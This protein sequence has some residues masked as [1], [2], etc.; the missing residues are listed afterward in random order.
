VLPA[1]LLTISKGQRRTSCG[2]EANG[3]VIAINESQLKRLLASF[4][5][6]Y[7]EDRTQCGLRKQTPQERKRCSG[8][9]MV[10]AWPGVGGLHH[11]YQRV[12]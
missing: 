7:H 8:R 1:T 12:A 6:Y 11:R 3:H 9:G 2:T 5:R 4:V 10:V